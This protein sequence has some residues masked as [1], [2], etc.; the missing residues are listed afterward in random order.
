[1]PLFGKS[2]KTAKKNKGNLASYGF[3]T[4]KPSGMYYPG[5]TFIQPERWPVPAPPAK[6]AIE[7]LA[8]VMSW[9][10]SRPKTFAFQ[11]PTVKNVGQA[12]TGKHFQ[13]ELAPEPTVPATT[14]ST[15]AS[16]TIKAPNTPPSP[17]TNGLSLPKGWAMRLNNDGQVYFEDVEGGT[18]QWN[19]PSDA[20]LPNGW[21]EAF[22]ETKVKFYTHPEKNSS[23]Y[24]P[25]PNGTRRNKANKGSISNA[26][27][28]RL[29]NLEAKLNTAEKRAANAAKALANAQN[30]TKRNRNANLNTL[31]KKLEDAE[32]RAAE[33]EKKLMT[34]AAAPAS[35]TNA[36]EKPQLGLA[37]LMAKRAAAAAPAANAEDKPQMGLAAMLAKRAA[38]AGPAPAPVAV[39]APKS[40]EAL[41]EKYAKMKKLGIP[42]GAI[43]SKVKSDGLDPDKY[44]ELKEVIVAQAVNDY[45]LLPDDSNRRFTKYHKLR[46]LGAKNQNIKSKMKENLNSG[47]LT[48]E[49]YNLATK[50][51]TFTKKNKAAVNNKPEPVAKAA[52]PGGNIAAQAAARIAKRGVLNLS[53]LERK[54]TAT[55]AATTGPMFQL[56]KTGINLNAKEKERLAKNQEKIRIARE[57]EAAKKAANNAA[58]E[59]ANERE[60]AAIQAAQTKTKKRQPGTSNRNNKG[61]LPKPWIHQWDE[62]DDWYV[63]PNTG[64]SQWE[65]PTEAFNNTW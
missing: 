58:R 62:E 26:N 30:K 23:W 29:K 33:A 38:A 39:E 60:Y 17:N 51:P 13:T 10:T 50:R 9:N 64:A 44:P 43:R 20:P 31:R 41:P 12:E 63:N 11:S 21:S 53:A 19:F 28:Q 32:R 65:R 57:A 59:A 5:Q 1:M 61:V 40:N 52:A 15:P 6:P 18:T 27:V 46:K 25:A 4:E 47:E 42:I 3:P 37:A 14:V 48:Q 24:R 22:D 35:T 8:N 2:A 34:A 36:E 54:P 56:K 7:P 49:A 55:G 45:F 16:L